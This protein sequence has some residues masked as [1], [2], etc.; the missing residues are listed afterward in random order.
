L[1]LYGGD[2]ITSKK[3]QMIVALRLTIAQLIDTLQIINDNPDCFD[4]K[5]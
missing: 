3:L 2:F 1:P 4:A 5:D